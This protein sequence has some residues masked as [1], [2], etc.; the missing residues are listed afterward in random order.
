M[1]LGSLSDGWTSR[2]HDGKLISDSA[3]YRML[4]DSV[5]LP[6]ADYVL[7]GIVETGLADDTYI[8]SSC[9]ADC[10]DTECEFNPICPHSAN[11]EGIGND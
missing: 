8:P 7:G 9:G 5:A 11:R 2:G 3:R 4:G 10:T 1:K 6:C